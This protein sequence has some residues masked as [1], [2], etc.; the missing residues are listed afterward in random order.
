M[1][2]DKFDEIDDFGGMARTP[3]IHLASNFVM[4]NVILSLTEDAWRSLGQCIYLIR[5][6]R[7]EISIYH[8]HSTMTS[9][10]RNGTAK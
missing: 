7:F 2:I 6:V 9:Q 4:R 5:E 1:Q 8:C 10:L 3:L